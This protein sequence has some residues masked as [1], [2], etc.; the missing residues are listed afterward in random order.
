[1]CAKCMQILGTARG[2][3]ARAIPITHTSALLSVSAKFRVVGASPLLSRFYSAAS[4]PRPVTYCSL[5]MYTVLDEKASSTRPKHERVRESEGARPTHRPPNIERA[6]PLPARRCSLR[7]ESH[8]GTELSSKGSPARGP[9]LWLC[10]AVAAHCACANVCTPV[11]RQ[12]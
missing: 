4:P 2:L 9:P 5:R 10:G 1:M 11:G 7:A 6:L 3:D 12:D 8:E